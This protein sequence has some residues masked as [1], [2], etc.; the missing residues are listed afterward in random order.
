MIRPR[1]APRTGSTHPPVVTLD[2]ELSGEPG[3]QPQVPAPPVATLDIVP[4]SGPGPAAGTGSG[5]AGWRPRSGSPA[6][7]VAT[8]DIELGGGPP[9]APLHRRTPNRTENLAPR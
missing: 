5:G 9:G 8:L 1:R 4:V 2:I 7:P 3:T 6:P